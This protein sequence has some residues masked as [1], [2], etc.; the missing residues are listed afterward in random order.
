MK[1]EYLSPRTTI[2]EIGNMPMLCNSIGGGEPG[3]GEI[4]PQVMEY[5][6]D[7]NCWG[8]PRYR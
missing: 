3:N 7:K 6:D 8:M 4:E 5:D 1:K 2:Y